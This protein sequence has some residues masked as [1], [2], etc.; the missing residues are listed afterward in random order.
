MWSS[1]HSSSFLT[2]SCNT[3]DWCSSWAAL[4]TSRGCMCLSC[5]CSSAHMCFLCVSLCA[6][7]SLW[8]SWGRTVCAVWMAI[9]NGLTCTALSWWESSAAVVLGLGQAYSS[10]TSTSVLWGWSQLT[11]LMN[12]TSWSERPLNI[13]SFMINITSNCTL[14]FSTKQQKIGPIFKLYSIFPK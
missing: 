2:L 11:W 12:R 3:S 7:A 6:G 4:G 10:C 1:V 14:N 9:L 5:V 8:D 13:Y